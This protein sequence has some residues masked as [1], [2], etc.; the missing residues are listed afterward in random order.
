MSADDSSSPASP[1]LH[2]A[3]P[4]LLAALIALRE[5]HSRVEPHHEDM[6]P[7][8]QQADAAIAAASV[9]ARKYGPRT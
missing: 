5:E 3:A 9:A 6:C 1:A 8:C 7:L 2:D 4:T